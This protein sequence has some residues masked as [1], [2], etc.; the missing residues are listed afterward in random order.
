MFAP[1]QLLTTTL[2]LSGEAYV[3][4]DSALEDDADS[5][6]TE[7]AA[8]SI[9]A[10]SVADSITPV[11]NPVDYEDSSILPLFNSDSEPDSVEAP[12]Y[13]Y[14]TAVLMATGDDPPNE[15]FTTP[16]PATTTATV[17]EAHRASLEAQRNEEGEM[18]RSDSHY[19]T[20]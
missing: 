18:G 14:P 11:S 17:I 8:G 9:V 7:S 19:V 5:A 3:K 12:R 2:P 16:L 15:P 13:Q 4:D 10:A 1:S 20:N 6:A